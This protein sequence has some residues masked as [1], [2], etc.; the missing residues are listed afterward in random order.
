MVE[1]GEEGRKYGEMTEKQTLMKPD[2]TTKQMMVQLI[3]KG[4]RVIADI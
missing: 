4:G 1:R 3:F 2:D